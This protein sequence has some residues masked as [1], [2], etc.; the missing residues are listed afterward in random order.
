MEGAEHSKDVICFG[1]RG[2]CGCCE[3]EWTVEVQGEQEEVTMP[4]EMMVPGQGG[5][6]EMVRRGE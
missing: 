3:G 6:L 1:F 2:P 5:R 4:S